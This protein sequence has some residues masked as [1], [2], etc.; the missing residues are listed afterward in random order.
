MTLIALMCKNCG[1]HL[2]PTTLKCE[3]CDTQYVIEG[4]GG[5]IH[6]TQSHSVTIQVDGE[7]IMKELQTA[8]MEARASYLTM[9]EKRALFGLGGI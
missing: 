1:A 9:N 8:V 4:K 2:N 3:Y 5:T 6:C 7:K